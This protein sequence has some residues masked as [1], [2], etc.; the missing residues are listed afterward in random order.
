LPV[1][2]GAAGVGEGQN[3]PGGMIID[4]YLPPQLDTAVIALEVLTDDGKLVRRFSSRPDESFTTYT[5][6]PKAAPLLPKGY[7][8]RRFYWDLRRTPIKNVEGIFV[9]GDYQGALVPPDDY[10]LQLSV[11]G[12]TYSERAQVQADPRLSLPEKDYKEQ[13]Q[14]LSTIENMVSD[15]HTSVETMQSLKNE[16]EVLYNRLNKLEVDQPELI[17]KAAEVMTLIEGWERQ[18][19][20]PQQ[21]TFQDVINFPNR[22]N[23]ELMNLHSRCDG[24][25]P[26]VTQGAQQRLEDLTKVWVELSRERDDILFQE[27]ENFNKLYSEKQLPIL[28]LPDRS[29][30]AAW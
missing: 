22:L 12:K 13:E 14:L 6:G 25:D 1:S 20:Q 16:M 7:G 8:I 3:P 5:G 30:K 29:S 11:N 26:R 17:E 23:A 10:I 4:Y 19:V 21:E 9:L 27:M 24:L 2:S 15:I 18:L 28:F